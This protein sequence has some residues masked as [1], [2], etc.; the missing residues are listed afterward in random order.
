MAGPTSTPAPGHPTTPVAAKPSGEKKEPAPKPKKEGTGVARPRLPK[1]DESHVIT[2]L[3]ENAKSRTANDRF[4]RY[5]TGMTIK[6]YVDKVHADF[7]R[8]DGQIYADIRWDADHKF[9]HIGPTVIPVPV[10]APAPAPAAKAS[11]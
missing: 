2:V 4:M 6:Q 11:A 5:K 10:A 9:I 8:T 7:D 1:P 3:K